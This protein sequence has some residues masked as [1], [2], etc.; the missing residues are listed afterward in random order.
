MEIT[1]PRGTRD[2]LFE[3]MKKRKEVEKTLKRIFE[4]YGYHEIKTPIFEDLKLFTLK[5][6]EEIIKQIYHFKDKANRDLALRPELTAPV[7]RLYLNEMR[8]HPKPIKL[9]YYGSCFRYERPQAGRFRQFWQFGCELMGAE[10][11]QAEAEV[12]ALAAHCLRELG[13]KEY[14]L[15]I[16]HLGILRGILEDAGIKG[17]SQDKIMSL[18][19]KGD[20]E[21]LKIHLENIKVDKTT[22]NLLLSIIGMKGGLEVLEDLESMVG[23]C[24]PAMESIN[25][26][27][28]LISL[29][30]DFKVEDY[31][32]NLGI[33]RGLDYYTGIVFEIYVPSLGAQKQ[34]CGGGT[35]NLIELFSG[36]K[37]Q[38]TGFAFGFDRLVAALK[39]QKGEIFQFAKV[40]VAPVFD[41]TRPSAY[42]IVQELREA[43]IPSDVDL[44]SRKLRKIL[45]YAD[46]LNVEKVILVGE[47]DL[48][49]GKVTI[50]DMKTGSQELVE[51]DKIIE[52][53]KEE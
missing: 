4:T 50:K 24:E 35:Y 40:F 2:F 8:K 15:H 43:G 30:D 53:L 52:Y 39:K 14:K 32:L 44:S 25:D 27:R 20:L 31:N 10:S 12:I 28:K 45:S 33:A 46:H 47:R 3:E 18:I 29:L 21:G 38:S 49:D 22:E 16:G 36:E 6:G 17:E 42:R 26:L 13:L 1:R 48:K 23:G 5:S 7:A 19:D 34:I 9:Y 11:P 41:S 37:I 51:I